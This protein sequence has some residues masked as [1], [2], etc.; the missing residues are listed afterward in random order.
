MDHHHSE[1][2]TVTPV[3]AVSGPSGVGKATL[4]QHVLAR[5]NGTFRVGVS[6]TTRK[7]RPGEVNGT[8][9]HFVSDKEFMR[10]IEHGH[11]IEHKIVHGNHYG[12]LR[13][14][15]AKAGQAG[16]IFLA[17]LDV[18][19]S[20]AL[21]ADPSV[22]RD[23]ARIFIT[24]SDRRYLYERILRRHG[25]KEIVASDVITR[26]DNAVAEMALARHFDFVV[27]NDE[28]ERAKIDIV[29]VVELY[30][31]YSRTVRRAEG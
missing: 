20:D 27:K 28:L 25:K 10:R 26:V 8:H 31:T 3:L 1:T 13:G 4:V 18:E 7:P 6:M 23:L 14:E 21:A 11:F 30:L 2:S 17:E 22:S 9:Y 24:V 19:G 16:Q 15:L 12:T 29:D 5:F